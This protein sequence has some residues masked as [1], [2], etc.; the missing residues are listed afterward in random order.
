M[1]TYFI[2]ILCNNIWLLEQ[3]DFRLW[4]HQVTELNENEMFVWLV[5]TADQL[6]K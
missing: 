2:I 6:K 5:A 4:F 3:L 1:T